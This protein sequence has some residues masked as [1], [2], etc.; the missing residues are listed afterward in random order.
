MG[1]KLNGRRTMLLLLDNLL[2]I[3]ASLVILWKEVML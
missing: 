1:D 3:S 2:H